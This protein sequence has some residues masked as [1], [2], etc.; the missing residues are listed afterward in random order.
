MT[1]KADRYHKHITNGE[2]LNTP[3]SS[4]YAE[5]PARRSTY[6][7]DGEKPRRNKYGGNNEAH[8]ARVT[9]S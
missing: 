2:I 5:K 4:K 6:Y 9:T 7:L 1:K 8:K 3:L